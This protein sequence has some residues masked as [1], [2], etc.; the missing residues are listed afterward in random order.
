VRRRIGRDALVAAGLDEPEN[1]DIESTF[2]EIVVQAMSG[3]ATRLTARCGRE[4]TCLSGL[5]VAR[6][7]AGLRRDIELQIAEGVSLTLT[8]AASLEFL[9][10]LMRAGFYRQTGWI[11]RDQRSGDRKG[12]D[13]R[14]SRESKEEKVV[15]PSERDMIPFDSVLD[16][17]IPVSISFGTARL[18]LDEALLLKE[19]S[20]VVLNRTIDEPVELQVNGRVVARGEVIAVRGQYGIRIHELASESDRME[21]VDP[22]HRPEIEASLNS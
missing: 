16:M 12:K 20:L 22:M 7:D 4:V 13:S 6:L 8:F 9:Q 2:Q 11:A 18:R 3:L 21:Y 19:G 10:Q 1:A 15:A 17:D 5:F 14:A